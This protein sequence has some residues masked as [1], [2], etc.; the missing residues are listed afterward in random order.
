MK[1]VFASDSF[2]GSLSSSQAGALL[3]EAALAAYPEAE[4][5]ICPIADGGEGTL[6][7]IGEAIEGSFSSFPSHD[8]LMRPIQGRIFV[9]GQTAYVEAATTCGLALLEDSEL[10]PL[11]ATSYG[12]GECICRALDLKCREIVIGLGG[13]C[14]NDGGAGCLK[15]LGIGLFDSAGAELQGCGDD[16]SRIARI[17][18]DGLHPRVAHTAFT[19]LSDVDN[20][21]LGPTGATYVYGRQ[22]GADD[23]ALAH[24]ESGMGRFAEAV[25]RIRP[26]VDFQ[27]AGFGAGGGLGMALSVFLGARI[28]SGIDEILKLTGFDAAVED[29]D[30]VVTGEG[31]LDG[32]SLRGKA[33]GGVVAHARRAGVPVAALCGTLA[34]AARDLRAM[35]FGYVSGIS[36]GQTLEYALAHAAQNYAAAAKTLFTSFQL[37]IR[38]ASARDFERI[39]EVYAAARSF[40]AAHGNPNQWGPTCW[41]PAELVRRDIAQGQSHVCE[42]GGR[43]VGVFFYDFGE[44]VEPTYARIEDGAWLDRSPYGVVHRIASDGSV[45][46]VG[47]ACLN[48]AFARSGHVRIDTHGDNAVMQRLLG[49]LGF[50]HCGTVYVEEDDYPRLAF[51]K[52]SAPR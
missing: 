50:S 7:A 36:D 19:I 9:S 20:P 13:S 43:I 23:A 5:V 32:Q 26:D 35:E 40:M 24:L 37:S 16:L 17:D 52:T 27:T 28:H 14:T 1:F 21:L 31:K 42:C 45:K 30:L 51:E 46:G 48:W 38:T 4:C 44:E 22:K 18:A 25:A 15:A 3:R 10:D 12:I 33:M 49:K 47:T 6:D 2:K 8:G 34:I 29:A 39:M 41:P 11:A